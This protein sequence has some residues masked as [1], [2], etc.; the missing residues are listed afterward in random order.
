MG[1]LDILALETPGHCETTAAAHR[2]PQLHASLV[3]A[4]LVHASIGLHPP[5]RKLQGVP[6]TPVVVWL[7]RSPQGFRPAVHD[8]VVAKETAVVVACRQRSRGLLGLRGRPSGFAHGRP[9]GFA[10][11]RPAHRA[12]VKSGMA[13]ATVGVSARCRDGTRAKEQRTQPGGFAH[14]LQTNGALGRVLR[15]TT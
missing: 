8:H 15:F 9:S 5:P 6:K 12:H 11:G 7:G 14:L 13:G 3:H 10:H 2:L 4:S 1:R